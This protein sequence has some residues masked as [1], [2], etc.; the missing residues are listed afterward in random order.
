MRAH[1]VLVAA[2]AVGCSQGRSGGAFTVAGST[3]A[4]IPSA[5]APVAS[6]ASPAPA[7]TLFAGATRVDVTPPVGVPLAGY[8]DGA[9]R[10]MPPNLDPNAYDHLLAPSTGERDPIY[11]RALFVSNGTDRVVFVSVD[12]I[13]MT[14]EFA[15]AV[16]AKAQALGSTVPWEGCLFAAV[17]THSGPGCLTHL[18]AWEIAAADLYHDSVFEAVTDGVARAMVEAEHAAVPARIGAG[19]GQLANATHNRRAG[20]SPSFTSSSI[21]PEL[22]VLRIDSAAGAPIATLWNFAIHG[23][24]LDSSSLVYSADIMGGANAELEANGSVAVFLNGAEGD[25]SPDFFQDQGIKTGGPLIAQAVAQVRS[26]TTTVASVEIAATKRV[27][28]FGQATLDLSLLLGPGGL[29]SLG[30]WTATIQALGASL[31]ASLPLPAGSVETELRF[32]AVRLGKWGFVSIP[33]EA[34]HTIGLDLKAYGAT[35]GYEHVFPC[36]LSNG[37]MGY[38]CTEPEYNAGGYEAILTLFGSKTADRLEAACEAQ[39]EAVKP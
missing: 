26:S 39:L 3:A 24:A 16:F 29:A 18:L 17:H 20:I 23:I 15:L 12:A 19:S 31:G 37:H 9:R 28:D 11:A 8:G 6:A 30:G 22:L 13:A 34:I 25:I 10:Q 36:G 5:V 7:P 33:G 14:D 27:V 4:P 35:L 2:L 1:A 21:D 38:V 32:Q